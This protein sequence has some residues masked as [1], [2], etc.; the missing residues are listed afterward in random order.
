MRALNRAAG[1]HRNIQVR[2]RK[3][4]EKSDADE[5]FSD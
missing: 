1:G 5:H 3:S 4:L 2:G